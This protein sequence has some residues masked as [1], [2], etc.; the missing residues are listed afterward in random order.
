[1]NKYLASELFCVEEKTSF[2]PLNLKFALSSK[3]PKPEFEGAHVY[4]ISF[5]EAIIFIGYCFNDKQNDIRKSRWSKQLESILF[6]GYRV[7]LNSKSL[8]EVEK[9]LKHKLNQRDRA[10]IKF[11]KTDVMTSKNRLIFANKHWNEIKLLDAKNELFLKRISFQIE[12]SS[13]LNSRKDFEYKV[14]EL[15]KQIKPCCNG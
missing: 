1:M 2:F 10:N 11:K 12:D 6:R 5:D 14:K 9:A 7:G 8:I 15:I 3:I 13:G 4:S